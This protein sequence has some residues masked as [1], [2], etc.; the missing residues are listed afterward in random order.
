MSGSP[1]ARALTNQRRVLILG[2]ILVVASI[3]ILGVFGHL[4]MGVFGAV[5]IVL[6][7]I[8]QLATEFTLLQAVDSGEELSRKQYGKA[9]LIRLLGI[10]V[11]GV[12]V[13]AIFWSHGGAAT[14]VGLA[15]FHLI[16]LIATG[17]PL[18]KE[19]KN[20]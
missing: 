11:A 13:T 2:L 10:T 16:T 5:G 15:L 20:V 4:L 6:G 12:A 19:L 7:M 17:F 18:L 9:S 3:W 8:N 1:L 14:L